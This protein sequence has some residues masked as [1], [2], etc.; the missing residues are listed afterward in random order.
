MLPVIFVLLLFTYQRLDP[1]VYKVSEI[2]RNKAKM[3]EFDILGLM[4]TSN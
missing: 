2:T 4:V 1:L 3:R